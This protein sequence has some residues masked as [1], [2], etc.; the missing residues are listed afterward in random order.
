ML[1]TCTLYM[2]IYLYSSNA[3]TGEALLLLTLQALNRDF[4][5]ENLSNEITTFIVSLAQFQN[6]TLVKRYG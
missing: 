6:S 2:N 4:I 1:L 5:S 3:D